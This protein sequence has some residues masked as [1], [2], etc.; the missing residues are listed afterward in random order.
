TG[1]EL[2]NS[3]TTIVGGTYAAPSL[4][5][6]KLFVGSWNG[7]SAADSGAIRAFVPGAVPP[8]PPPPP[9]CSGTQP[10]VL[11]GT[12]TIATKGDSNAL[13]SAEAFQTTT[14]GC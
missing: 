1:N 6:G 3:G 14:A 7:Q 9:S 13:G 12:Q 10:T 8:P 2:W 5:G 11:L 4:G